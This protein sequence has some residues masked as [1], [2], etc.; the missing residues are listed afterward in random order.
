[1]IKTIAIT[2]LAIG[3]GACSHAWPPGYW[4]F[5]GAMNDPTNYNRGVGVVS[6]YMGAHDDGSVMVGGK[7]YPEKKEEKEMKRARV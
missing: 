1:M 6:T 7:K 2:A 4:E 3:L 5:Y